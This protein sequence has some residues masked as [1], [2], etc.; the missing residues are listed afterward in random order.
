MRPL[1]TA[2]SHTISYI[3]AE[4]PNLINCDCRGDLR[5]PSQAHTASCPATLAIADAQVQQAAPLQLPLN[6][7]KLLEYCNSAAH[8]AAREGGWRHE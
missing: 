8:P 7:R 2:N 1:S 5:V 4:Q 6:A 3:T